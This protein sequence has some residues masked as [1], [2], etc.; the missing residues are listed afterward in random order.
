M[1]CKQ[2]GA[3][4]LDL[5]VKCIRLFEEVFEMKDFLMPPMDHLRST[6]SDPSFICIVATEG[7]E[8]VGGLTGYRLTQYYSEKPL[9]YIYD[10]AVKAELQRC[11]IGQELIRFT[12]NYAKQNGFEEVYV[13][14]DRDE[15]HAVNFYH[16]TP[17]HGKEEVIQFSYFT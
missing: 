12:N 14:T 16:K 10:L 11:G 9:L 5:F 1:T 17:F 13:Q 2:L 15:P 4:K 8:V 7:E 3:S 6:L